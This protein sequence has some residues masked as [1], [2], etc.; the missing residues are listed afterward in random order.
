MVGRSRQFLQLSGIGEIHS[1][2]NDKHNSCLLSYTSV[3]HE[4]LFS[5]VAVSLL[6]D[7]VIVTQDLEAVSCVLCVRCGSS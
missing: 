3:D 7:A 1:S 6:F 2:L 4:V 5:K